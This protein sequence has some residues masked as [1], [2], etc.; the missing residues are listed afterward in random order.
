MKALTWAARLMKE[1]GLKSKQAG[2]HAYKT[3]NVEQPDLPNQ[4]NREFNVEPPNKV[5][6]GDDVTCASG[7]A[8]LALFVVVIALYVRRIIGG[9]MSPTPDAENDAEYESSW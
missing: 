9:S 6:C 4:L 3:A 2:T 7:R 5:W 1:H 8:E